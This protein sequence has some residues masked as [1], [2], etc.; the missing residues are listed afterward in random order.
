MAPNEQTKQP[1]VDEV[2]STGDPDQGYSSDR[3][4]GV[5]CATLGDGEPIKSTQILGVKLWRPGSARPQSGRPQF[6]PET[7]NTSNSL[8]RLGD[9]HSDSET[10]SGD[11]DGSHTAQAANREE[12]FTG[13][14][15]ETESGGSAASSSAHGDG[16]PSDAETGGGFSA[17]LTTRFPAQ[18]FRLNSRAPPQHVY[19]FAYGLNMNYDR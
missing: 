9:N 19:Y 12:I 2:V 11:G 7:K 5:N 17:T 1:E 13:S 15:D 10:T 8:D 18:C 6:S 14:A 16:A 4:E 3:E